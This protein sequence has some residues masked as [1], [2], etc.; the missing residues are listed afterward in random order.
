M[1]TEPGIDFPVPTPENPL[2]TPNYIAQAMDVKPYTVRE[3]LRSGK[4]KGYTDDNG[5]WQVLHN[6]FL[7]FLQ[8]RFG[9][10]ASRYT[11]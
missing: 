4:L 9:E 1:T 5:N 2:R 3:W 10:P 7:A 11:E 8:A 6:D